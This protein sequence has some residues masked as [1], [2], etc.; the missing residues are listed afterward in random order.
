MRVQE[1]QYKDVEAP[2]WSFTPIKLNRVNLFVGDTAT[3]KTRL[4]NTIFNLGAFA[5]ANHFLN[6]SWSVTFSHSRKTYRWVLS[7]SP[8]EGSQPPG[9]IS[10]D[11]LSVLEEGQWRNI[12]ERDTTKFLYRG[13]PLPKLHPSHPSIFLLKEEPDIKP[14]HTAFSLVLRRQFGEDAPSKVA[15]LSPVPPKL[16][17]QASRNPNSILHA[18]LGL[19]ATLYALYRSRRR[20]YGALIDL[21]RTAF[22]S[23]VGFEFTYI[24]DLPLPLKQ[25]GRVP[26]LLVKEHRSA[27]PIPLPELSSGMKKVLLI[28]TDS[29]VL[30]EGSVY[31]IDEYENSLGL[32]AIDFFP[33][34]LLHLSKD[35]QFILTSHHPYLINAIPPKHWFLFKREGM[36]VTIR[37][38]EELANR[39]GRSKQKAFTQLINDPEFNPGRAR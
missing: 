15:Q 32:S 26:L 2:G 19:S 20:D 37:F 22:P 17:K 18:D 23:V 4:L 8:R 13:A 7:T 16:I 9:V 35:I 36:Q 5:A 11:I 6:G 1:Y 14:V 12:V 3:G 39:F 24:T 25:Q 30:P 28:L 21:Y 29:F 31:M 38:G 27:N 34:F 33:E 10:K